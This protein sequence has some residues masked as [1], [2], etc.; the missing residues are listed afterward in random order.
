MRG[1]FNWLLRS[2]GGSKKKMNMREWQVAFDAADKEDIAGGNYT[3]GNMLYDVAGNEIEKPASETFNFSNETPSRQQYK[4]ADYF[5]VESPLS[6]VKEVDKLCLWTKNQ[7]SDPI[8]IN[9]RLQR[10]RAS[11][12]AIQVMVSGQDLKEICIGFLPKKIAAKYTGELP[13]IE[14]TRLFEDKDLSGNTLKKR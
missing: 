5:E 14:I 3:I 10:G 2:L 4:V 12:T 8:K 11:E 7:V 13:M 1:M 9:V 6:H